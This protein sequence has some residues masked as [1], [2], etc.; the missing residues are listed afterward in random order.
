MTH[1]QHSVRTFIA[2]ALLAGTI[3][4]CDWSP[5]R[6]RKPAVPNDPTLF[7][8]SEGEITSKRWLLDGKEIV[9]VDKV[10][11]GLSN[12]PPLIIAKYGLKGTKTLRVVE[13]F[14]ADPNYNGLYV[15]I[16]RDAR[17]GD[18]IDIKFS[19]ATNGPLVRLTREHEEE[20]GKRLR[21]VYSY[22]WQNS[23]ILYRG[24]HD[25]TYQVDSKHQ[26]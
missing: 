5:S 13:F 6:A 18:V 1:L 22:S 23:G 24:L 16:G 7:L 11:S 21:H 17:G 25:V 4:G 8:H 12:Q 14:Y 20:G 9:F 2:I 19:N 15:L 3:S 10:V 26:P